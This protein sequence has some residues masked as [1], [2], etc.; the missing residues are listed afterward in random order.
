[1]V[2]ANNVGVVTFARDNAAS[3][4]SVQMAVYFVRAHPASGDEK[5]HAYVVHSSV[6]EPTALTALDHVGGG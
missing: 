6:L 5:P 3:P 1:L 2:F 4:L